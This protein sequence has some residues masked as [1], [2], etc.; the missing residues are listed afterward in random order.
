MR[1]T[2]KTLLLLAM[3]ACIVAALA[4][5]VCASDQAYDYTGV[6]GV[7]TYVDES[8]YDDIYYSKTTG[9]WLWET[10]TYANWLQ[11]ATGNSSSKKDNGD[12]AYN[13]LG[14]LHYGNGY[15]AY[16]HAEK[17]TLVII[18]TSAS[19]VPTASYGHTTNTTC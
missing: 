6:A 10:T 19:S 14:D 7:T 4:V 1:R 13:A 18:G 15:K 16:F 3:L 11:V 9:F 8:G 2:T 12:G 17:K 5:C